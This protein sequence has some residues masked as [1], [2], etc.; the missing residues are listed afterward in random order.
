MAGL[1]TDAVLN[2]LSKRELVQL[3]LNTD[4]NMGFHISSMANEI[5]YLLTYFKSNYS[6]ESKWE[7][8]RA[9]CRQREIVLGKCL[10]STS[11]MHRHI[12]R[13]FRPWQARA[14]LLWQLWRTKYVKYFPKL[15][16]KT[17]REIYNLVVDLKKHLKMSISR[18][19][20]TPNFPKNKYFLP[21]DTH[22]YVSK[23]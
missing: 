17:V 21:P 20:S 23:K 11:L 10:K 2:K 6:L 19:R 16:S 3:V 7:T 18:R 5:K 12:W 22:T 15:K 4:A 13:G 8:C 1:H 9:T 14:A